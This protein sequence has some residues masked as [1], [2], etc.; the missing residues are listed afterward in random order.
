MAVVVSDASVLI[1]LGAIGQFHI[2]QELYREIVVPEAVWKEVT[3]SA[4]RPGA[5]EVIESQ[6]RGWLKV[7]TVGNEILISSLKTSL[8]EGEAEAIA[9]ARE[10]KANLLLIDEMEG[11]REA[12]A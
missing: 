6:R 11:R 9:L 2:L 4:S 8:G 5:P 1:S 10:M 12:V 7:L 3:H